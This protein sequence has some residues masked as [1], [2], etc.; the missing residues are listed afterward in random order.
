MFADEKEWRIEGNIELL[1]NLYL[2]E[3]KYGNTLQKWEHDFPKDNDYANK[4][5]VANNSWK[6]IKL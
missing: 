1:G 3:I 6:R 2:D 5:K 4:R